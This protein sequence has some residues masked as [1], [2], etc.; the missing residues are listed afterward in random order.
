M[1]NRRITAFD[2]VSFTQAGI[3]TKSGT[4]GD[5]EARVKVLYPPHSAPL[6]PYGGSSAPLKYSLIKTNLLFVGGPDAVEVLV[7]LVEAK[8]GE[9]GLLYGQTGT[10]TKTRTAYFS[11]LEGNWEAPFEDGETQW[12]SLTAIFQPLTAWA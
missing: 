2:G 9:A 10:S 6:D 5:L 12:L 7:V 3:Y 8:V 4:A 1:A 11:K